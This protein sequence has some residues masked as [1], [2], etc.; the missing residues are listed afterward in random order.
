MFLT[1]LDGSV[2]IMLSPSHSA[3][4]KFGPFFMAPLETV[5]VMFQFGA[6]LLEYLN[7]WKCSPSFD[8]AVIQGNIMALRCSSTNL[9]VPCRISS[10]QDLG[11]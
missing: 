10:L 2:E 6:S 5:L 3:E 11:I 1:L 7:Q 8:R 9:T 4:T